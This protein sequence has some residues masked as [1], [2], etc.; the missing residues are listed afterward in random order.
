MAIGMVFV[1]IIAI[2]TFAL[3]MVFGYKAITGF[4]GQGERV[5]FVTFKAD[6]ESSINK[7]TTEFGSVSIEDFRLPAKYE[8]ICFVN[9]DYEEAPIEDQDALKKESAFAYD[10]FSDA[11][12]EV[13]GWEA[14]AENIFLEP[15]FEETVAI[16]T[17]R[18]RV[19]SPD[20][21][22]KRLF[23]CFDIINGQF[24]ITL[25][26]KGDATEISE[27]LQG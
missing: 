8:K 4:V 24:Q 26:G 15:K 7:I 18:L 27:P 3:I 2:I 11:S 20:G 22:E 21:S 12:L 6:L 17:N 14:V 13:D 1:F 10:T 5:E 9:M 16:K 25:E 23:E 19:S